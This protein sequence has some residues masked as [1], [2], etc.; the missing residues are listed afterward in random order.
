MTGGA[1]GNELGFD[2]GCSDGVSEAAIG[3]GLSVSLTCTGKAVGDVVLPSIGPATLIFRDD[4]GPAVL[5]D[6]VSVVSPWFSTEIGCV[7][8]T[9]DKTVV[10]FGIIVG[11]YEDEL[12]GSNGQRLAPCRTKVGACVVF[13]LVVFVSFP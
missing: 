12:V 8:G 7:V 5:L 3:L 4:V 2:I 9:C 11:T 6:A 1:D 13:V 10:L